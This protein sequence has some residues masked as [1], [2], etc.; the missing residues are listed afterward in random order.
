MK[1]FIGVFNFIAVIALYYSSGGQAKS[2]R[3][4]DFAVAH[5]DDNNVGVLLLTG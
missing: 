5:R 4:L 1:A 3:A 2:S